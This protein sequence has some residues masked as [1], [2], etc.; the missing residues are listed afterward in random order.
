MT[1]P[2]EQQPDREELDL[3]AETLRDLEP[4]ESD[5]D[6]VKGGRLPRPGF[7]SGGCP[8]ASDCP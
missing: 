7:C 1:D 6:E 3:D 5:A 2:K 4:T 8:T